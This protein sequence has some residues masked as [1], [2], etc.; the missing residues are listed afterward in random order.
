MTT[1]IEDISND[2]PMSRHE[3]RRKAKLEQK[4]RDS[5]LIQERESACP[6]YDADLDAYSVAEF[7]RRNSISVSGFYQMRRE[8]WGPD[9]FFVGKRQL[10]SREAAERWRREREQAAKAGTDE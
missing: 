7:C 1:E 6:A 8:R 10:I 3:R 2:E 9:T 4:G 5:D